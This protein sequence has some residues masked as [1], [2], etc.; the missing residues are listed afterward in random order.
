MLRGLPSR[1]RPRRHHLRRREL[2]PPR[3]LLLGSLSNGL[4]PPPR[5]TLRISIGF[6]VRW[7]NWNP[8][9]RRERLLQRRCQSCPVAELEALFM[10]WRR[11][12]GPGE[13][14][15]THVRGADG[16]AA[17]VAAAVAGEGVQV[18]LQHQ[19][20]LFEAPGC[21]PRVAPT[22]RWQRSSRGNSSAG[23]SLGFASTSWVSRA[24]EP[25][26][27]SSWRRFLRPT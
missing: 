22:S 13:N 23:Q 5:L 1:R 4:R 27:R 19:L 20:R 7:R 21:L 11:S 8:R 15:G 24:L 3:L 14:S 26:G 25:S 10:R 9:A 16:I 6:C 12:I 17:V 18:A 2:P